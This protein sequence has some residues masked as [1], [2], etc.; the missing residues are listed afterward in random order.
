MSESGHARRRDVRR[1]LHVRARRPPCF[2]RAELTDLHRLFDR[3]PF[4]L[5]GLSP[6]WRGFRFLGGYGWSVWDGPRLELGHCDPFDQLGS[7]VR[8]Q[9]ARRR[10]GR[11]EPLQAL[12]WELFCELDRIPAGAT[13]SQIL[14]WADER[15]D[16]FLGWRRPP[17]LPLTLQVDDDLVTFQCLSRER[18]WVATGPVDGTNVTLRGR[19]F[20]VES[21]ALVTVTDL[22]TYKVV[23]NR[24]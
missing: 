14:R 20:D 4:P 8:V 15:R 24:R 11:S 2:R 22:S 5:Y 3:P 17:W 10:G 16:R 13:R 23:R 21:V 1:F 9:V 6:V 19:R 18:S 7:Q 12:A